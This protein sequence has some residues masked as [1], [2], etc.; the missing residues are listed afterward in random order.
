MTSQGVDIDD[1]RTPF[2]EKAGHR[3]L[4]GAN[5]PTEA[6]DLHADRG[7]SDGRSD[8]AVVAVEATV[9]DLTPAGVRLGEEHERLVAFVQ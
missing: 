2:G 5:A 3:G 7:V 8:K 1:H 6:D 4:P 9:E